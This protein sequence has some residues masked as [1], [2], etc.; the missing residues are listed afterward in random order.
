MDTSHDINL[1]YLVYFCQVYFASV[2]QLVDADFLAVQQKQTEPHHLNSTYTMPRRL[3]HICGSKWMPNSWEGN[4]RFG[5]L[6]M[7]H[8]LH[9]FIH[10]WAHGQGKRYQH[11]AHS[12]SV[13]WRCWLG[14]RK[15]I[16]PVKNRVVGYWHGYLSGERCRHA[17][18]PADAT[19]THCLLLQ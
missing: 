17:Y 1:E 5:S 2:L 6:A 12:P 11:P 3:I 9:W 15:G 8:R 19:A 4:C 7:C 14:G 16:R 10:Q 13:L 18:G